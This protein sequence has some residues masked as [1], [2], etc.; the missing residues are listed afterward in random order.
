MVA[1]FHYSEKELMGILSTAETDGDE[2]FPHLESCKDCQEKL[3]RASEH[4]IAIE[5]VRALLEPSGDFGQTCTVDELK[6]LG[7]L[8]STES[9]AGVARFGRYEVQ[10]ILG[11][12]GMGIVMHGFDPELNRHSAIKV[13]SPHLA[14]SSA[15][16]KRFSRE[17]KSAAAVVHEHVV[18]IHT[19]DVENGLPYF[20]MPVIEGSSLEERVR[21]QGPL[22]LKEI[23]RI[24][25][26]IASGLSAAHKQGLVHRDVKP[27]NVLLSG[28][29]ERVML[30]D[31]GLARAVDDANLTQSGVISGTPQYMSPEQAM[32]ADIGHQSDLFSLGSVI[33]FMC[34]GHSPFRADTT[35]GVLHR[36]VNETPRDI[37]QANA[38]IPRWLNTVVRRL[39]AKEPAE[40]FHSAAEVAEVLESWLAH[41]QQPNHVSAPVWP[42]TREEKRENTAA[43]L[44]RRKVG[45]FA[46]SL[47]G[48]ALFAAVA[49]TIVLELQKGTL[50]IESQADTEVI[51]RRLDRPAS[52]RRLVLNEN[53]DSKV[54]I[55]AGEY[56]IEIPGEHD[57]L[58]IANR[59][60]VVSRGGT[61]TARVTMVLPDKSKSS[62]ENAHPSVDGRP[63][64]SISQA[65]SRERH[66]S[67]APF[68]S[69]LKI[70]PSNSQF[71]VVARNPTKLL[72]WFQ[73]ATN[74]EKND[75]QKFAPLVN[76]YL[77]AAQSDLLQDP[78][79]REFVFD[80]LMAPETESAGFALIPASK[81]QAIAGKPSLVFVAELEEATYKNLK[82]KHAL[83]RQFIE[84]SGAPPYDNLAAL[85]VVYYENGMVAVPTNELNPADVRSLLTRK[86][87]LESLHSNTVFRE[88]Y[89]H[90]EWPAE[91]D[92]IADTGLLF[93]AR[94]LQS[95]EAIWGQK[96]SRSSTNMVNAMGESGFG[97]VQAVIGSVTVTD[98]KTLSLD[99]FV[100]AEKPLPGS[101]A[102][103]DFSNDT[104]LEPPKF[105]SETTGAITAFHWNIE[106]AFW[107]LEAL[108]DN[109]AGSEGVFKEVIAGIGKDPNGPQIDI[110]TELLP[111]FSGRFFWITECP[112]QDVQHSLVAMHLKNP[113]AMRQLVDRALRNEPDATQFQ[114]GDVPAWGIS[115]GAKSQGDR[116]LDN[117]SI[118]VVDNYLL[119]C[120]H[121]EVL[122]TTL[123][124]QQLASESAFILDRDFETVQT[125]LH[126]RFG[127]NHSL[128]QIQTSRSYRSAYHLVRSGRM[129][130]SQGLWAGVWK[131]FSG[132]DVSLPAIH[133]APEFSDV[134]KFLLP[135]GI[136]SSVDRNGWSFQGI[137]CSPE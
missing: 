130:E 88:A 33:Y 52:E 93:Y 8:Q 75:F 132:V 22:E 12:G 134:S 95:L 18:P 2:R 100:L 48:L 103:L 126:K 84:F 47:M 17:A 115:A 119:Y 133:D 102:I 108:V 56:L 65:T 39:L 10:E 37:V 29:V 44:M 101:A 34:T 91:L 109:L 106:D 24:A 35:M 83:G 78:A 85:P 72:A 32:G 55:A 41:V 113:G 90:L 107:Q 129:A 114:V 98:T 82:Q 116:L 86:Q 76:P 92:A 28:A 97:S 123:A 135:F 110:R 19:V 121:V 94:P 89:E 14:H 7:I 25:A 62:V 46:G 11:R 71:A 54:R 74:Y 51:I 36:I 61:W 105:I 16:R 63:N 80:V 58:Q 30:T 53:R 131:A 111:L 122:K 99:S 96:L 79:L 73:N 9:G 1:R 21:Q 40:R 117:W 27:A 66:R 127:Q 68:Q 125:E 59:K 43:S 45:K 124:K 81:D 104:G 70:L 57:S 23:L 26:Q 38:D 49:A 87:G 60:A 5:E 128:W 42:E 4:G 20:V 67:A 118:C 69:I 64:D 6:R 136:V 77:A 120:S 13:L 112:Q 50:V 31:F 15:A 3:M 137:I